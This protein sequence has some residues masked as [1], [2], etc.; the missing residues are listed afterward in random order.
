MPDIV[1]SLERSRQDAADEL[2]LEN[3][4]DKQG[5]DSRYHQ[6]CHL[7]PPLHSVA[8]I[9]KHDAQVYSVFRFIL[10]V[11]KRVDK[12]ILNFMEYVRV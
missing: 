1:L 2:P 10:H 7:S 11:D 6:P 4:I 12:V 8:A 3:N 5:R 9:Q